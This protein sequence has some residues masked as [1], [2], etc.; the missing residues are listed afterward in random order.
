M[1][2]WRTDARG[3]SREFHYLGAVDEDRKVV[4]DLQSQWVSAHDLAADPG[5]RRPLFLGDPASAPWKD[6]AA[7]VL[8]GHEAR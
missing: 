7:S 1:E 6:L 4:L 5:E 8:A 2:T 3:E